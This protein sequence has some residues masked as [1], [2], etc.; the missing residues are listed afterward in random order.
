MS[1][2]TQTV[3]VEQLELRTTTSNARH[4]ELAQKK[5]LVKIELRREVNF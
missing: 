5:V 4:S 1:L 3:Y 2:S